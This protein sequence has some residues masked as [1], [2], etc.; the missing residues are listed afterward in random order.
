MSQK[1]WLLI[2]VI[3]LIALIGCVQYDNNHQFLVT[4]GITT[5]ITS[6]SASSATEIIIAITPVATVSPTNGP[7]L[8]SGPKPTLTTNNESK[9][10]NLLQSNNCVLPCYMS[11][12]PGKTKLDDAKLLLGSLGAV[13]LGQTASGETIRVGYDMQFEDLSIDISSTPAKQ[14]KVFHT[15]GLVSTDGIVQQMYIWIL[16]RGVSPKFQDYWSR[17]TPK[18]TFLQL[19][20]PDEVYSAHGSLALEYKNLEIINI[21]TTFWRDGQLCPQN[22][23]F[24]FDRRFEIANSNSPVE[25]KSENESSLKHGEIWQPIEEALGVSVEEF[26]EQVLADDSVCFDIKVE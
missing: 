8:P 15:L 9:M 3:V 12:I 5:P 26:Y 4:P 16:A 22:E 24:Y 13:Y 2:G 14:Q 11:I 20:M 21:Y 10:V 1:N 23:T 25:L 6:L 18:G 7:V 17:Y 19:G